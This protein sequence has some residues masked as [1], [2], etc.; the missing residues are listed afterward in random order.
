VRITNPNLFLANRLG[1][2]NLPGVAWDL[3]PWSFVVN[4]FTNMGQ[5]VNSLTDFV[6]VEVSNGS[7]TRVADLERYHLCMAGFAPGQYATSGQAHSKVHEKQRRRSVGGI[8]TP[9]F[10]FRL[11][12]LNLELAGIAIALILQKMSRIQQILGPSPSLVPQLLK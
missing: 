3:I 10:Q 5:M 12:E 2:L 6:G 9:S 7:S 1:L 4:M 11:P 8:P